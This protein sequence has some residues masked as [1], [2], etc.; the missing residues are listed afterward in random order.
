MASTPPIPPIPPHPSHP[1]WP[2]ELRDIIWA[3][4][5]AA[6]SFIAAWIIWIQN[7]PKPEHPGP[8]PPDT[9]VTT[10]PDTGAPP[11]A[12]EDSTD[13]P[14]GPVV[15]PPE[16]TMLPKQQSLRSSTASPT[17]AAAAPTGLP[18]GLS[19]YKPDLWC[20]GAFDAGFLGM[21][22]RTIGGYLRKS[23]YCGVEI[24][25]SIKDD[26]LHTRTGAPFSLA[27]A[28]QEVDR[29]ALALPADTLRKYK[30]Y[31]AYLNAFDDLGSKPRWGTLP[32][33]PD[34]QALA[35]YMQQKVGRGIV[36]VCIRGMPQQLAAYP[37]GWD[38]VLDCAVVQW[39]TPRGDQKTLYDKNKSIAAKLGIPKMVY[40]VNVDDC[41]G[42]HTDPCTKAELLK[43]V[44]LAIDYPGN[45]ASISFRYNTYTW[46]GQY[47]EA[48]QILLPKA[49]AKDNRTCLGPVYTP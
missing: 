41:D 28:K 43:Y 6:V 25:W 40:T 14:G 45:C 24:A 31:I 13:A 47:K 36:P 42:N 39:S 22:T 37:Q 29:M 2:P 34:V 10:P 33:L 26:A 21:D 8:V 20:N 30:G 19:G 38:K 9:V 15:P 3:L 4:I 5:G 7:C 16:D 17:P 27:L 23:A 12:P 49:K 46:T 48:W 44:G 32:A 1:I 35:A 11:T 18:L